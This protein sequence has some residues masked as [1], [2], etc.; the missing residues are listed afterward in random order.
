MKNRKRFETVL[1]LNFAFCLSFII[2]ANIM[3]LKYNQE[4]FWIILIFLSLVFILINIPFYWACLWLLKM[5]KLGRQL[6]KKGRVTGTVF[7]LLFSVLSV[8]LIIGSIDL[9]SRFFEHNFDNDWK[10]LAAFILFW[11]STITAVYIIIAY[12]II[13]KKQIGSEIEESILQIGEETE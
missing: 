1:I 8:F 11:F 3:N 2:L 12:W 9:V 4:D 13:R 5:H 10:R 6:S 7:N